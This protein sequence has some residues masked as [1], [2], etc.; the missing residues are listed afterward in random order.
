MGI[1]DVTK[2]RKE[3]FGSVFERVYDDVIVHMQETMPV[4]VVEWFRCVRC[5]G[6][7]VNT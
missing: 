5:P 3:N 4:E 1:I 7:C 6:Q 2:K